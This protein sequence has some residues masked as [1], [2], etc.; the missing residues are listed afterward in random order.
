MAELWLAPSRTAASPDELCTSIHLPARPDRSGSAY[1]RLEYRRAM[2]IAVVGAGATVSLADDGSLAGL[3]VALTAVAPVILPVDAL[4]GLVG[5]P[6]DEVL[7]GEVAAR[8]SEQ[9]R[10]ISDLRA[11]DR[12]RRN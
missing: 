10:P 6:V 5:R 9:A 3:R 8:A 4:D 1:V 12:Y 7:L 11:T 2:E